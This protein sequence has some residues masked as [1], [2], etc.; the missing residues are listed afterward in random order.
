MM[1][2]KEGV[3]LFMMACGTSQIEIAEYLLEV[4]N[5]D[6]NFKVEEREQ[7]NYFAFSPLWKILVTIG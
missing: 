5:L 6:I 1:E 4:Y 3:T 7:V 2:T